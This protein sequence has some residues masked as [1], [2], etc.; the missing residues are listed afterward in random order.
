[1]VVRTEDRARKT[2]RPSY[3]YLDHDKLSMKKGM[4]ID[5]AVRQWTARSQRVKE[6]PYDEKESK[7]CNYDVQH[8]EQTSRLEL[9]HYSHFWTVTITKTHPNP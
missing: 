4:R 3:I 5:Y 1:M 8:V 6:D 7:N 9:G 2:G